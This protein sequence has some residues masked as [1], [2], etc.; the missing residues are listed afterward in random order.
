MYCGAESPASNNSII[1]SR[2][3]GFTSVG[4]IASRNARHAS[5]IEQISS[6]VKSRNYDKALE[7]YDSLYNDEKDPVLLY[8]EALLCI[9]YSNYL[10]QLRSYDKEGFMEENAA[11]QKAASDLAARAKLL[12]SRC[13]SQLS[14]GLESNQMPSYAYHLFLAYLKFGDL[15]AAQASLEIIKARD[16]MLFEYASMLF[17]SKLGKFD[18]LL[19]H[20]EKLL[21]ANWQ[22]FAVL[23]YSAYALFKKGRRK[24]SKAILENIKPFMA[25]ENVERLLEAIE[26]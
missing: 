20:A 10:L 17:D 7:L 1:C 25:S 19:K 21:N 9:D 16:P 23:Y 24:E 12:L 11:L 4:D 8:A 2:C 26:Q 22:P 6:Y 13:A 5:I 3:E 14:A 15:A 18:D